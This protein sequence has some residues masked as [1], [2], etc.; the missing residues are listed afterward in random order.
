MPSCTRL[1]VWVWELWCGKGCE[2][3]FNTVMGDEVK[4]DTASTEVLA[5]RILLPPSCMMCVLHPSQS[6]SSRTMP[7]DSD[8]S[9]PS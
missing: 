1:L 8:C 4:M 7:P 9:T 5:E 2:R 6:M 3:W